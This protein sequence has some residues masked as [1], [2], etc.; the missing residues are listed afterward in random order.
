[1]KKNL[2]LFILLGFVVIG[3]TSCDEDDAENIV[4][5]LTPELTDAELLVGTWALDQTARNVKVIGSSV[6]FRPVIADSLEAGF[7]Q[8]LAN[9][10]GETVDAITDI[11]SVILLQELAV[12]GTISNTFTLGS[13]GSVTQEIA[14]NTI[15]FISET[16]NDAVTYSLNSTQDQITFNVTPAS[17]NPATTPVWTIVDV[18]ATQLVVRLTFS[19]TLDGVNFTIPSPFDVEAT[20][21]RQ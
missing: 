4:N 8:G 5:N 11:Y 18:T 19:F 6:D 7:N 2:L 3:F 9:L 13:D 15:S 10:S 21:L 20:F 14:P 1:M 17:G 16:G 12:P